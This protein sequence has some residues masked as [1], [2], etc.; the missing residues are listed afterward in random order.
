VTGVEGIAAGILASL[1]A[2]AIAVFS[3][4]LN[5]GALITGGLAWHSGRSAR[6]AQLASAIGAGGVALPFI[7]FV[8]E[9]NWGLATLLA[10][11]GFLPTTFLAA[12]ERER[13]YPAVSLLRLAGFVALG[14]VGSAALF[15]LLGLVYR[16]LSP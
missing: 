11:L 5:L 16:A 2:L 9:R 10:A 1:I 12:G 14:T 13:G 15:V 4:L 6:H 7:L 3:S 8:G